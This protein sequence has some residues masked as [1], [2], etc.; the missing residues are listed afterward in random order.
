MRSFLSF[1]R[2]TDGVQTLEWVALCAVI[3][4]A[5]LGISAF[6]LEGADGLSG[7]VVDQMGEAADEVD[8]N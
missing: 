5:A 1:L 7:A 6:I 4:L 8:N 2:K 3:V